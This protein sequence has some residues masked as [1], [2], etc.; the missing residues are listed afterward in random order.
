MFQGHSR[1]R[2]RPEGV[3]LSA[4]A[5]ASRNPSHKSSKATHIPPRLQLRFLTTDP[6]M[7]MKTKEPCGSRPQLPFLIQVCGE[8]RTHGFLI[9][10][11]AGFESRHKKSVGHG[12]RQGLDMTTF[13]HQFGQV[14]LH[15]GVLMKKLPYIVFY[16]LTPPS[17][18][19]RFEGLR[20]EAGRSQ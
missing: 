5:L 15:L 6:G 9:A 20:S 18:C 10:V 1:S 14:P 17:L 12:L 13:S 11:R 3:S 4:R 8:S 19:A 2:S 7:S 16:L